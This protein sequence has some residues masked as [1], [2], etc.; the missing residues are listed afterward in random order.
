MEAI[1]SKKEKKGVYRDATAERMKNRPSCF[2]FVVLRPLALH[3]T[4]DLPGGL[5][6][7]FGQRLDCIGELGAQRLLFA[8]AWS[9]LIVGV[10]RVNETG[11]TDRP[12]YLRATVSHFARLHKTISFYTLAEDTT[13]NAKLYN[14]NLSQLLSSYEYNPHRSLLYLFL[15]SIKLN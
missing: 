14:M 11:I 8:C 2:Y 3:E 15:V 6:G 9:V 4:G 7:L 5:F 13:T 12:L 1:N 10:K